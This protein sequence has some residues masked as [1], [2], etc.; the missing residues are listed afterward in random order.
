MDGADG[1]RRAVNLPTQEVTQRRLDGKRDLPQFK[2]VLHPQHSHAKSAAAVCACQTVL[3]DVLLQ[4]M[5]GTGSRLAATLQS[6]QQHGTANAQPA[7][8]YICEQVRFCLDTGIGYGW[9]DILA[10]HHLHWYILW[11]V[12][13]GTDDMCLCS[14]PCISLGIAAANNC[15]AAAWLHSPMHGPCVLQAGIKASTAHLDIGLGAAFAHYMTTPDDSELQT[16]GQWAAAAAGLMETVLKQPDAVLLHAAATQGG[17]NVDLAVVAWKA[18][19]TR[20]RCPCGS[21]A[22]CLSAL[23]LL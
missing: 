9:D 3:P 6:D 17:C 19:S 21:P 18:K 12:H 16:E 20:I 5:Q 14:L 15:V 11:H 22:I 4:C 7:T 10:C 23:I 2:K 1:A 13:T 8:K